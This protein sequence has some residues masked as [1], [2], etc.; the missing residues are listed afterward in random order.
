[1]A[2]LSNLN[3]GQ[4]AKLVADEGGNLDQQVQAGADDHAVD[5]SVQSQAK[6][7]QLD[8]AQVQAL[9]GAQDRDAEQL[10]QVVEQRSHGGQQEV[11]IG[12]QACHHQ[13]ADGEDQDGDE[14]KAHQRDRERLVCG[15]R[16]PV[17]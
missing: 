6:V 11:L 13:A 4:P 14:V 15:G 7:R 12:M 2:A 10:A 16:N 1:M 5:Q 9:G 17:R 8:S 3:D